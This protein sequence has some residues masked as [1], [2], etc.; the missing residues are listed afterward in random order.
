MC[1]GERLYLLGSVDIWQIE[2]IL[3]GFERITPM[4]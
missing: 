4:V 3:I 2:P 1:S